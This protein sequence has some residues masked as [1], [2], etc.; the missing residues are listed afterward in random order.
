MDKHLLRRS[1]IGILPDEIRLRPKTPV[2]Q[3]V[4][5]LQ[6]ASGR[7]NPAATEPPSA[8]VQSLVDWAQV[9]EL[10]QQSIDDS[11]YMHLRPVALSHWLKIY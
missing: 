3:D 11:L 2:T 6:A 8:L 10:L 5:M 1:Q 4:L 9:I 7:W